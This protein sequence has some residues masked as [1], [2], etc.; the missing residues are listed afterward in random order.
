[1]RRNFQQIALLP[2][3][4]L[5]EQ[6]G[7]R[8]L[9][10]ASYA[11]NV[12]CPNG[13]VISRP[14]Y[15][16]LR[17]LVVASEVETVKTLGAIMGTVGGVAFERFVRNDGTGDLDLSG[18]DYDDVIYFGIGADEFNPKTSATL[19]VSYV[20]ILQGLV[21]YASNG[22]NATF[23]FIAEYYDGSG[24][25]SLNFTQISNA[26]N[27]YYTVNG[28]FNNQE[29]DYFYYPWTV[30]PPF[31]WAPG[32]TSYSGVDS[33]YWIRVTPVQ[34]DSNLT[35]INT[36]ELELTNSD[37]SYALIPKP[38]L[39]VHAV[40]MLTTP[41]VLATAK[42]T[43]TSINIIG[44]VDLFSDLAAE[45]K[46]YA[47]SVVDLTG[48][49]YVPTAVIPEFR[50]IFMGISGTIFEIVL[51]LNGS[52]NQ[53]TIQEAEIETE[54]LFVGPLVAKTAVYD[55][56][57]VALEKSF[58]KAKFIEWFGNRLWLANLEDAPFDV[59]WTPTAP[60]FKV[61]PQAQRESLA[62]NDNS[63]ITAIKGFGQ[64]LIVFK[65][66]SIWQMVYNGVISGQD[67]ATISSFLPEKVVSGVGCVAA[68]SVTEV[69][70][71]LIFL[72][73]DGV[74][75]FNGVQAT[76][77]S[78]KVLN[79]LSKITQSRREQVKAVNWT[80]KSL[81]LMAIP[82]DGSVDNNLVVV[83]D[84]KNNTW[85]LWDDMYVVDWILTEDSST[86]LQTLQFVDK[87]GC[88]YEMDKGTTSHGKAI[89]AVFETADVEMQ[90]ELTKRV[91]GVNF[92][93]ASKSL[94]LDVGVMVDD[95]FEA[96]VTMA[97]TPLLSS[98]EPSWSPTT[99]N[100]KWGGKRKFYYRVAQAKDGNYFRLRVRHNDKRCSLNLATLNAEV[101][102][103]G[104]R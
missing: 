36:F 25:K 12:W 5:N 20:G 77:I 6:D 86:D 19:D 47:Q 97:S 69:K 78:D 91:R 9:N 39:S 38:L 27:G 67:T 37:A 75:A 71:N 80:T 58:P 54:P 45:Y 53:A 13:E 98:T 14:G 17:P 44:L 72:A 4:G 24:W 89:T 8:R 26:S 94:D 28:L 85:W 50:T 60:Y 57:V 70:G 81:Y 63:P 79:T 42:V 102:P 41:L 7:L 68:G 96:D 87:N 10:E 52:L 101:L 100:T 21:D 34:F 43:D 55:S 93:A 31:D 74:Y 56:S 99:V 33:F 59:Q 11:R 76:R 83:W 32:G 46:Y 103:L 95:E 22:S 104:N 18:F 66:D 88:L 73:E 29:G 40:Q 49:Y 84:Y 2:T 90:S 62:E 65:N 16:G 23:G 3:G 51:P 82:Y 35:S 61:F 92:L 48:T 1:M 15:V 64:N 30:V